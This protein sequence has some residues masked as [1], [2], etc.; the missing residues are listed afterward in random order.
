MLVVLSEGGAGGD[1]LGS[2]LWGSVSPV[3][4]QA[5]ARDKGGRRG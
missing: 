1:A 2:R 4:W 3:E 5:Q